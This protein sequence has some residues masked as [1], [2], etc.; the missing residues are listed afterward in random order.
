MAAGPDQE[1]SSVLS[2]GRKDSTSIPPQM[3]EMEVGRGQA[4]TYTATDPDLEQT[5]DGDSREARGPR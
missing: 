2:D 5:S 3:R 4:D 1:R